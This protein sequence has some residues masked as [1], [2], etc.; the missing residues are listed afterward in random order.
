MKDKVRQKVFEELCEDNALKSKTNSLL[1]EKFEIQPYLCRLLPN[2]ARLIF[3]ARAKSINCK[4]NRK[5]KY[6]NDLCRIC[7]Q[8]KEEQSHIVNCP[9][10]F[11]NGDRVDINI[12]NNI[13]EVDDNDLKIIV[14]R[15]EIFYETLT[16]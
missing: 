15:L 6:N 5:S 2:E 11:Q 12:V 7:S 3:K 14:S 9:G 13:S 8:A 10:L 16:D 1:Y 4:A